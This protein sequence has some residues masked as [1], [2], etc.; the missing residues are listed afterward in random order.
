MNIFRVV[1]TFNDGESV[2]FIVTHPGQSDAATNEK[3]LPLLRDIM[4]PDGLTPLPRIS[5]VLVSQIELH[6][7]LT[8]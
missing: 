3:V 4:G 2:N 5:Q 1:V 6:E 7:V 8:S